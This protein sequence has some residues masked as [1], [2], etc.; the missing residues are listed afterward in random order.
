MCSNR[1]LFVSFQ[2]TNKAAFT[3]VF[4][5]PT[6]ALWVSP[7]RHLQFHPQ[8]NCGLCDQD[9]D[10]VR[11]VGC[12]VQCAAGLSGKSKLKQLLLV[13]IIWLDWPKRI[14]SSQVKP[15]VPEWV[16]GD[17]QAD[18][19]CIIH[20]PS[21]PALCLAPPRLSLSFHDH[22]K[23]CIS[24]ITLSNCILLCAH[25]RGEYQQTLQT[26]KEFRLNNFINYKTIFTFTQN[27]LFYQQPEVWLQ[28][29]YFSTLHVV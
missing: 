4:Q 21:L 20:Q 3:V 29:Y 9:R 24:D 12:T 22:V 10:P 25:L 23:D 1:S 2:A 18:V 11:S 15:E 14:I 28:R 5:R 19:G 17:E 16:W 26:S 13:S 7:W 8:S 6:Q 27:E